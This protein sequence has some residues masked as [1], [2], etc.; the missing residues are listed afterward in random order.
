MAFPESRMRTG[1]FGVAA[2]FGIQGAWVLFRSDLA[3]Y[4]VSAQQ[5]SFS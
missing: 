1:L 4:S 5:S 2:E 3:S